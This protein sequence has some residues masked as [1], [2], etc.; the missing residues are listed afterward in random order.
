SRRAWRISVPSWSST[1]NESYILRTFQSIPAPISDAI[2]F[3]F[4]TTES[5]PVAVRSVPTLAL[6]DATALGVGA[7]TAVSSTGGKAVERRKRLLHA[8]L[9]QLESRLRGDARP[10]DVRAVIIGKH[11]KAG[12]LQRQRTWLTATARRLFQRGHELRFPPF[13][14]FAEKLE[15]EVNVLG[16]NP[17]HREFL[18]V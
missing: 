10:Q 18:S 4:S 3:G 15:T 12:Q 14:D 7:P 5:G 11:T 2:S 6:P 8:M 13:L 1:R 16:T 17:F 9:Q